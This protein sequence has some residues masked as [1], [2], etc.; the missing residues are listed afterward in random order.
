MLYLTTAPKRS[1]PLLSF[2][3]EPNGA[4][5]VIRH[6]RRTNVDHRQV[7]LSLTVLSTLFIQRQGFSFEVS[8]QDSR[9]VYFFQIFILVRT[10]YNQTKLAKF[11]ILHKVCNTDEMIRLPDIVGILLIR[12]HQISPPPMAKKVSHGHLSHFR[13]TLPSNILSWARFSNPSS[14]LSDC[15]GTFWCALSCSRRV[16]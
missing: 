11:K 4:Q 5:F 7:L 2:P 8:I 10:L 13:N 14:S 15:L 16:P 1:W 9:I 12:G 6:Y 3:I